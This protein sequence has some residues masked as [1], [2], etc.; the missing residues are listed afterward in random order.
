MNTTL[1]PGACPRRARLSASARPAT[2]A[3][4]PISTRTRTPHRRNSG[5][6]NPISIY[7]SLCYPGRCAPRS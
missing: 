3:A 6:K 5:S 1:P 4:T 2:M 7:F